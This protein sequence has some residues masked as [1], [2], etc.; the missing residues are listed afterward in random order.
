MDILIAKG[1]SI[2]RRQGELSTSVDRKELLSQYMRS[3]FLERVKLED[4]P[5]TRESEIRNQAQFALR[6]T[7]IQNYVIDTIMSSAYSSD[8]IRSNFAV[9]V[10]STA[11]DGLTLRID[12]R[13]PIDDGLVSEEFSLKGGLL[14]IPLNPTPGYEPTFKEMICHEDLIIETPTDIV[15]T[16]SLVNGF[17]AVCPEGTE[18]RVVLVKKDLFGIPA[19]ERQRIE[20]TESVRGQDENGELI[21]E[22]FRRLIGVLNTSEGLNAAEPIYLRSVL[23]G[24]SSTERVVSVEDLKGNAVKIT[25]DN[26]AEDYLISVD[27]A[28]LVIQLKCLVVNTV[29]NGTESKVE[30][31]INYAERRLYPFESDWIR[32]P[33]LV[34]LDTVL[35]PG[36]YTL[37]YKAKVPVQYDGSMET[38]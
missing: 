37:Y 29:A 34:L 5:I 23:T 2:L 11:P 31:V 21:T 7:E 22:D 24:L 36:V 30:D 4:L 19:E 38:I 15:S 10:S 28:D 35:E 9:N 25:Y 33:R 18:P 3:A 32:S 27:P 6:Q 26:A 14:D 1:G 13:D 12:Y 20:R 17:C 8:F 16:A